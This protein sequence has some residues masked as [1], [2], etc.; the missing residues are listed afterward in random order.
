MAN[1][2][3]TASTTNANVVQGFGGEKQWDVIKEYALGPSD[4]TTT[5]GNEAIDFAKADIPSGLVGEKLGSLEDSINKLSEAN[6]SM[7]KGE[8]PA[9]VSSAV[10][11][12]AS[13]S[14]IAGGTFGS[15]ARALSARDLG[16]T[17]LDIKQQGIANESNIAQMKATLATTYEGIRQYN[18]SRNATL[19]EL[20]IKAREQNLSA[21]DV[22]RQRIATNIE[23]NINIMRM[24]ADMSIQQQSIAAQ[25]AAQGVDT[26][27]IISSLDKMIAEFNKKLTT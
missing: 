20:S 19:A 7:L 15:S 26:S 27:N 1:K 17:S 23:A 14:S 12:A 8:I 3:S 16:R 18:L 13:E 10:R 6:A 4:V 11:R 25:A 24:I 2:T 5:P 22:E 21:I 9:D